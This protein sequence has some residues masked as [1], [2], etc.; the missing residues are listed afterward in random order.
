M[1]DININAN[2]VANPADK[3]YPKSTPPANISFHAAKACTLN[4]STNN[5][6]N[7]TSLSFNDNEE[8]DP[9]VVNTD[10]TTYTIAE[11]ITEDIYDISFTS[12]IPPEVKRAVKRAPAKIK[13]AAKKKTAAKK[14]PAKKTAKRAAGPKKSAKAAKPAKK[15]PAK[16]KKPTRKKVAK[17]KR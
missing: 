15:K 13:K 5:C 11:D 4:F 12:P 10:D 8:K 3:S 2:F 17:K 7:L 1:A 9:P 16:A 14:T 6:F